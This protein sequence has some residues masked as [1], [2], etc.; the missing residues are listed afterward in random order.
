MGKLIKKLVDILET[1][2]ICPICRKN[3]KIISESE[4]LLKC[5]KC[6]QNIIILTKD[7]QNKYISK[8]II[9]QQKHIFTILLIITI[10]LIFIL[11]VLIY[12]YRNNFY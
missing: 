5:G 12:I 8:S 4:I 1:T 9:E 6:N 2:Y 7:E 11:I 3:Y 10:L